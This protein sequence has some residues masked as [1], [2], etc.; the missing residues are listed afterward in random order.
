MRIFVRSWI[1]DF[2]EAASLREISF[3]LSSIFSTV[4]SLMSRSWLVSLSYNKRE[5]T[6][7]DRWRDWYTLMF[8]CFR[9]FFS[10]MICRH[11]R[12]PWWGW[13]TRAAVSL[14]SLSLSSLEMEGLL[15]V[16]KLLTWVLRGPLIG[17][18]GRLLLV[19]SWLLLL[20]V[21]SM[22][23][24]SWLL[25]LVELVKPPVLSLTPSMSSSSVLLSLPASLLL[26]VNLLFSSRSIGMGGSLK[27]LPNT[28]IFLLEFTM[29]ALGS[30]YSS[31]SL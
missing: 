1:R 21:L 6:K 20:L 31:W 16:S 30:L 2:L 7:P 22:L 12:A 19:A 18:S 5:I 24:V 29:V 17:G 8:S 23:L 13:D 9:E 15:W 28:P 25:M 3:S 14:S 11:R 10:S 27:L 4:F 26:L